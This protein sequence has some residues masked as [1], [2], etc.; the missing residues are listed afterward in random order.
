MKK[1]KSM[2]NFF[3]RFEIGLYASVA[4][5]IYG[6]FAWF[7]GFSYFMIATGPIFILLG[8]IGFIVFDSLRIK[9]D[10]LDRYLNGRI[11]R[12]RGVGLFEP[13]NV[14]RT[15]AVIGAE[16]R[17]MGSDGKL[18]TEICHETALRLES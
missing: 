16:K 18:R 11:E 8:I 17:K 4:A 10:E 13:E 15:F 6:A 1:T 5:M 3:G 9:T 7:A 14:F 2:K 12:A